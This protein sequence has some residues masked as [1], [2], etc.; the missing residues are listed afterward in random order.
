MLIGGQLHRRILTNIAKL[1]MIVEIGNLV[2][3]SMENLVPTF[4]TKPFLKW[5]LI[6][7]ETSILALREQ[8]YFGTTFYAIKWV[9]VRLLRTN[10]ITITTTSIYDFIITR[11][12]WSL[13]LISDQGVH[14]TTKH[15]KSGQK[16]N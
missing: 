8:V 13:T 3:T 11:F 15:K 12:Q 9:E 1:G 14:F 7:Y 5:E 2:A 4:L 16:D 10:I 6:S